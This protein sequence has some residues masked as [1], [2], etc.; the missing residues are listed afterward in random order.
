[1]AAAV[2]LSDIVCPD[3]CP[4]PE[5]LLPQPAE[6]TSAARAPAPISTVRFHITM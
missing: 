2:A 6:T 5:S 1:V 4:L 3:I